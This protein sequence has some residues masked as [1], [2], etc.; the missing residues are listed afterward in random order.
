M[1]SAVGVAGCGERGSKMKE[2]ERERQSEGSRV[3]F[4]AQETMQGWC[5]KSVELHRVSLC[6]VKLC[7][8]GCLEP[9]QVCVETE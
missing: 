8:D 2:V 6:A 5:M 7:A 3:R 1:M 4:S 9:G